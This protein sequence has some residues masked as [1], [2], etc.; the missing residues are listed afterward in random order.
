MNKTLLNFIRPTGGA[1][2]TDPLTLL[3]SKAEAEAGTENAK[4]M[5]PLRTKEAVTA[6]ALLKSGGTL[7][8]ALTLPDGS[9]SAPSLRTLSSSA[10]NIGIFGSSASIIFTAY[11]SHQMAF[12]TSWNGSGLAMQTNF[13]LDWTASSSPTSSPDLIV[14]RGGAAATLQLGRNHASVATK[15]T[16]KAHNTVSGFG[17]D[18]ELCPG[19]G[20]SGAGT[21][22][23]GTTTSNLSFFGVAGGS[24][25]SGNNDSSIS[26]TGSGSTIYQDTEFDGGLAGGSYTIGGL[27]SALKTLGLI[28]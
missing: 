15:Q 13:T 9:A 24:R 3:A 8:G 14:G 28:G 17:A 12:A 21:L 11:G 4:L 23:M 2:G 7:T 18:L 10:N 16:I 25:P 20:G 5:T 1:S 27:V 26:A 6:L 19:S 22:R